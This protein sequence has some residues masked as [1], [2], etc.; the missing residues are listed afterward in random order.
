MKRGT[1]I[2]LIVLG[3]IIFLGII[4]GSII[5]V[6]TNDKESETPQTLAERAIEQNNGSICNEAGGTYRSGRVDDCRLEFY[7]AK[8]D[9]QGCGNLYYL[10][11]EKICYGKITLKEGVERCEELSDEY[12]KE[13]CYKGYEC[14]QIGEGP[15][16]SDCINLV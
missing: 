11:D 7:I 8:G 5:L 9:L 16:R 10:G 12:Y 4:W 6:T 1:R 13:I 14:Y 2:T 3:V 15:E